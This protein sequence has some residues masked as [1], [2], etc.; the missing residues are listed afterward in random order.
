MGAAGILQAAETTSLTVSFTTPEKEYSSAPE[1]HQKFIWKA[2]PTPEKALSYHFQRSKTGD[3]SD[4]FTL[5]Q[6]PDLGTYVSGLAE[7]EYRFRVRA[8]DSE[9]NPL[10]A[11]SK[12]IVVEVKYVS[13]Q[14]VIIMLAS[15]FVVFI[16]TCLLIIVGHFRSKKS[17]AN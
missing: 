11:W 1:G 5:Y 2:E 14:R 4:A 15:G 8:E 17:N 3:F 9:G 6:G 10:S 16:A 12:P 13:S 7:R